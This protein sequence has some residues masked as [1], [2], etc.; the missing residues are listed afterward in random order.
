MLAEDDGGNWRRHF[1]AWDLRPKGSRSRSM[2]PL[3]SKR[4]REGSAGSSELSSRPLAWRR[5]ISASRLTGNA[6]TGKTVII[7]PISARSPLRSSSGAP[8]LSSIPAGSVARSRRLGCPC[9][10]P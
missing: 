9:P 7:A 3:G 4:R 1:F 8:K 2:L 10:V 6:L 5:G